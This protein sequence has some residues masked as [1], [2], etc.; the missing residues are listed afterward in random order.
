MRKA[1]G[2]GGMLR[3]LAC[4]LL[5]VSLGP[6]GAPGQSA[7]PAAASPKPVFVTMPRSEKAAASKP[8][9][10]PGETVAQAI[11][12]QPRKG[13][14]PAAIGILSAVVALIFG[15]VVLVALRRR[16]KVCPRCFSLLYEL[17]D[18]DDAGEDLSPDEPRDTRPILACLGCGEVGMLRTG[19]FFKSG[20]Q[21]PKCQKWN[22]ASRFKVVQP[23][24]YMMFGLIRIE[25]ACACG[26]E[27]SFLRSTPPNQAPIPEFV[28]ASPFRA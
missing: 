18:P 8:A 7:P 21:C 14:T 15:V 24:S 12:R 4:A 3:I 6:V 1:L 22:L 17:S 10:P 26:H 2:A 19:L 9:L 25:E 20:G 27:A 16:A 28:A 5:A 11:G 23:S 13:D